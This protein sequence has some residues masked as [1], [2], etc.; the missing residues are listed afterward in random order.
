M[1]LYTFRNGDLMGRLTFSSAAAFALIFSGLAAIPAQA[2]TYPPCTIS[3]TSANQT[4]NGT[5]GNDVICTGVGNYIVNA[6]G[7]NDI[8]IVSGTGVE[9]LNARSRNHISL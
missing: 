7:G 3:G 2:D 4:V 5:E 6:L 1:R 8:I 9:T